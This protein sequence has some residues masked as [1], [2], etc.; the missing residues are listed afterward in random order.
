VTLCWVDVSGAGEAREAILEEAIHARVDA[1][2]SRDAADLATVPPTVTR[3]LLDPAGTSA[4]APVDIVVLD[5]QPDPDPGTL[6]FGAEIARS[7][8]VVD[9]ETLE[10]AAET[11]R[12]TRWSVVRF[13]DPTKIPLEILLAAAHGAE[14]DTIVLAEDLEEATVITGVLEHGPAGVMMPVDA[15]GQASELKRACV[16]RRGHLD[17]VELEVVATAHIGIGERACVDTCSMLGK[18]EGLLVGSHSKG[19]V[20]CV[21]ETHPLPYM[22]TRDFRVNAG[23]VH[24]YTL[25][26]SGRTTYLSELRSG[27]EVL[28]VDCH[29]G[30]RP[31]P[32][33]RVKIETRPLLSVDCVG[34]GGEPVNLILQ[35]DW[36]VRVLGPGGVVLNCTELKPGSRVLGYLPT[37]D[38]H[39]GYA[40]DEFCLER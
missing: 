38:R 9:A 40:I 11:A 20:L 7:V 18:D 35:D 12:T 31:T 37:E 39:V 28:I 26:G 27:A 15:V 8:D 29:G 23:A 25:G 14:G 10:H 19:F 16:A 36:H 21:S 32:L 4:D 17:L 5:G 6:P 22:P 13:R 24:S 34:P 30:T 2:A 1:I 33:G 3:V